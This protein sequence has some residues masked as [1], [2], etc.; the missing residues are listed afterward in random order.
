MTVVRNIGR[1]FVGDGT[2]IE[3]GAI[4]VKEGLV[5]FAGREDE[6]P[7]GCEGPELDAQGALV[8]PGLIDAHSHPLYG[9][10]RFAE[11]ALRSAGADYGEIAAAG[12]GIAATVRATRSCSAPELRT[13]LEGRLRSWLRGGTTTLEAK[14]GYHLDKE[15]E[16]GAV[17]LL[18]ELSDFEDGPSLEVTFLG[19]HAAGPEWEGDL[20]GYAAA[21]CSWCPEAA[22]AGARHI[23][24]FCD[25]GYFSPAQS[26]AI[27]SA[28]RS[29]GLLGRIHA[30]ELARTGGA[31]V[32]AALG[33]SSAD[34][35]LALDEAGIEALF[36]GGVT[37]TLAPV[38][39]L[40][41]GQRPPARRLLDR[42][43][44]VALGSDHNPGTCGTTSMSLVVALAV[45][46]LGLSVEEA[47]LAATAGGAA[48]LRLSD[49]G[50]LMPG[51]RADLVAWPVEHEGA[52]A[53]SYGL[54][55]LSVMK[56]GRLIELT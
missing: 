29:A 5:S 19:A 28:G 39:S 9:G 2:V 10:E 56:A 53:W 44:T 6:L 20:D 55:P 41:M 43:V 49:R 13:N 15:G 27:L 26:E 24:V 46:V 18:R 32:A 16:L 50:V 34:H 25:A 47:L 51:K 33:C 30:D 4:I 14:T 54:E 12:G 35:L 17:R 42:G 45:S 8:T 40:S 31:K 3:N 11:I 36:H 1:L 52:F 22:A 7:A 23:D 48:S 37:A 38:T 21:V